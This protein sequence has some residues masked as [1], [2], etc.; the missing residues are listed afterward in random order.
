MK[1]KKPIN[2]A[3]DK[4]QLTIAIILMGILLVIRILLI[5][6][7]IIVNIAGNALD[8]ITGGFSDMCDYYSESYPKQDTLTWRVFDE[9]T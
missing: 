9:S 8:A 6:T 5:S 4:K 1:Q 3:K 7:L 2:Q